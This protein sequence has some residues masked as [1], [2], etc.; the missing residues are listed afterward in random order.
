VDYKLGALPPVRPYGLAELSVYAKG[1]LPTPP[2]SVKVPDAKWN[3]FANGPDPTCTIP[4]APFGDCTNAAAANALSAWNVEVGEDDLVPTSNQVAEQYLAITDG[5]DTGCVESDVLAFWHKRG[6]FNGNKIAAYAPVNYKNILELHTAIACYG[7]VYVGVNLPTS[8][9]QATENG[10]PWV[11]TGDQPV[12]GHA[13]LL[14]GFGGQFQGDKTD[15][16]YGITWGQVQPISYAWLSAYLTEAWAIV[17]QAF[18]EAGKGPDLDLDQLQADISTLN[19]PEVK[20]PW[21][22]SWF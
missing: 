22:E 17:P 10:E 5:A 3:M 12:G 1:K 13:L 11:Y 20:C 9:M 19:T 15:Y 4:G 18:V 7:L 14:S 16:V 2:T 8:A 21:W 6:L